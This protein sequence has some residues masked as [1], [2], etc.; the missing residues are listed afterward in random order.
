MTS[1][2]CTDGKKKLFLTLITHTPKQSEKEKSR[3]KGAEAGV[4][5][6]SSSTLN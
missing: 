2:R 1:D 4:D 3:K 6:T 5:S